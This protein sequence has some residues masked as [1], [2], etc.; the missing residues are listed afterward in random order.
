[1]ST[2]LWIVI[3]VAGVVVVFLAIVALQSSAFR[4][5]RSATISAPPD[6]VFAR[7][8]DLHNWEDWS[9]WAKIDPNCG[10]TYDGPRSGTG[11]SFA[12]AGNKK[13]GEGRMTITDSRPDELVRIKLEFF[14][15]F[16][17]TNTAEF[18]FQPSGNGTQVTWSM[19]GDKGFM[20]KVFG[21]LMNMD[22]MVGKDF[23]KGLAQMKALAESDKAPALAAASAA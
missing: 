21:L 19:F 14:K 23:E 8:N 18:T 11:S 13:V 12:W 1:M 16:K 6:R 10:K 9:P 5:S 2:A 15:P 4:V 20:C 17:A 22:K 7:V 3:A